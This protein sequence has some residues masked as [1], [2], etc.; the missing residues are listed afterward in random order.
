MLLDKCQYQ[1]PHLGMG[2]VLGA[3]EFV[4][5]MGEVVVLLVAGGNLLEDGCAR[6]RADGNIVTTVQN[7]GGRVD[8]GPQLLP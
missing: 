3:H 7:Q 6:A 1:I 8:L 2:R 5:G 4:A